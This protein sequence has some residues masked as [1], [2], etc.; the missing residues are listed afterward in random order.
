[1]DM[2]IIWNLS[3]S[4]MIGEIINI[5]FM[6]ICFLVSKEFIMKKSLQLSL[7]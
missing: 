4:K 7:M 5:Y 1:M 3:Y 6:L 2:R